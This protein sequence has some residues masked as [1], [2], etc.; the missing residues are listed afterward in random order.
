MPPRHH[1]RRLKPPR[2]STR[3]SLFTRLQLVEAGG[4]VPVPDPLFTRLQVPGDV[5]TDPGPGLPHKPF[6]LPAP[7]PVVQTPVPVPGS[8]FTRLQ[9]PGDVGTDPEPGTL[10][11]WFHV[12]VDVTC[13]GSVLAMAT[14]PPASTKTAAPPATAVPSAV[15]PAR[16]ATDAA[17]FVI[18]I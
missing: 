3:H 10:Y 7:A 1:C 8:L 13:A 6:A 11:R 18:R 14:P 17:P 15:L 9:V 5:G 4:V 16:P 2:T 12:V